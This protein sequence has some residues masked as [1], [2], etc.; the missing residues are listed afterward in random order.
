MLTSGNSDGGKAPASK[1]K[2]KIREHTHPQRRYSE[3][4]PRRWRPFLCDERSARCTSKEGKTSECHGLF[5]AMVG[6]IAIVEITHERDRPI[7]TIRSL[8]GCVHADNLLT[9][10]DHRLSNYVLADP[11]KSRI[12]HFLSV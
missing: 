11:H 4:G 12:Y 6:G 3:K 7:S 8:L 2:P 10:S 9:L 1:L 5:V